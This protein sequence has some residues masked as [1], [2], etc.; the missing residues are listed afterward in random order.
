MSMNPEPD[1]RMRSLSEIQTLATKAARGAGCPWGLAEEAGMSVRLL[2]CH[3]L[4]G[5]SHLAQLLASPHACACTGHAQAPA[6]GIASLARLSDRL[7]GLADDDWMT[8]TDVAAPIL[9]VVPLILASRRMGLSYRMAF[10]GHEVGC[11]PKGLVLTSA[12]PDWPLWADTVIV[13]HADEEMV[14]HPPDPA[15][16][17]V[18][19][20]ALDQLEALAARTLVPETDASRARGAGPGGH[21]TD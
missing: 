16:R 21:D 9:M 18:E 6:C 5:L 2:E 11:T 8:F 12:P 17:A 15:G 4:P 20:T 13:A 10:A 14:T 3:D 7:P 19:A 1:T